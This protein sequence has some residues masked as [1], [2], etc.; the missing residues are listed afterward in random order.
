MSNCIAGMLPVGKWALFSLVG[1]QA[2]FLRGLPSFLFGQ[3][4]QRLVSQLTDCLLDRDMIA[5]A[6]VLLEH[7]VGLAGSQ[8][9]LL[10]KATSTSLYP[11]DRIGIDFNLTPNSMIRYGQCI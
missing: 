8:N 4:T 7:L 3:P 9:S 1:A 10:L 6:Q 5:T 11:C 2:A